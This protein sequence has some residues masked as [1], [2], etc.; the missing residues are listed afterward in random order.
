M[1]TS[2]IP[3]QMT[4]LVF[5]ANKDVIVTSRFPDISDGTGMT[6]T[7]YIKAD[8]ITP[9]TDITVQSYSSA[10]IS[11]PDNV[12]ATMSQFIIPASDTNMPGSW[13]WRVDVTDS[14]GKTRTANCGPL[15]IQAV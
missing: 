5:Y 4:A 1:T 10:V 11:D 13:W 2:T 7:F 15:L 9:D 3:A 12:G 6:S 14:L 8:R